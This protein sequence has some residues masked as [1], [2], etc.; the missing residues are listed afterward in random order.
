VPTCWATVRTST[1]RSRAANRWVSD[2]STCPPSSASTPSGSPTASSTLKVMHRAS[3][4]CSTRLAVR[5]CVKEESTDMG[6]QEASCFQ[7]R[8]RG[9]SLE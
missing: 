1:S 6:N 3:R 7:Y 8:R 5:P 4:L 9:I 2:S